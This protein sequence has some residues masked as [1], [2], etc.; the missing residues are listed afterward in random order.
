MTPSHIKYQRRPPQHA[1]TT[2]RDVANGIAD[3]KNNAPLTLKWMLRHLKKGIQLLLRHPLTVLGF[4][5]RH[6]KKFFLAPSAQRKGAVRRTFL[7]RLL[8]R[9]DSVKLAPELD[10]EIMSLV[11]DNTV[12]FEVTY[13]GRIG[14]LAG[15]IDLWLREHALAAEPT[16]KHVLILNADEA[17]N[18]H[19]LAYC[20]EHF[21]FVISKQLWTFL[22]HTFPKLKSCYHMRK[23]YF[24]AFDESAKCYPIYASWADRP[25]LFKLNATDRTHLSTTLS[26]WGFGANDWFVCIHN[27]EK[28]YSPGDDSL[29]DYRNANIETFTLAIQEI[30][31]RG[32]WV[33]RMGDP[34]MTPLPKMEHVVDYAH[35]EFRNPRLDV[36]LCASAR[37]FIGCSS[38]LAF[39][40]TAFGVPVAMVNLTPMSTL[41]PGALDLSIPKLYYAED[42][43][44]TLTFEEVLSSDLGNL[45]FSHEYRDLG[46][47]ILD[48]DAEDILAITKEILESTSEKRPRDEENDRLQAAFLSL[49]KPG[50]Y[51]F[52][53]TARVGRAFL[54]KHH[55]LLGL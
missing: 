9:R 19:F 24:H 48:N 53:S 8:G 10:A 17:A 25:P 52:G 21:Q 11:G 15:E 45:R 35:S 20:Q 29:H 2:S 23:D 54:S 36:L 6:P 13:P 38:G 43:K 14:H 31:S 41:A 39:L 32:G 47:R 46:V 37:C 5:C 12:F 27:R 7:S 1:V 42:E 16:K 34:S 26:N 18:A 55:D 3:V 4:I 40:A 49:I 33:I 51:G 44:R 28:G 30:V 22:L 50:H